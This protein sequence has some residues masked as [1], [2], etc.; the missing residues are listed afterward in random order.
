MARYEKINIQDLIFWG[1][2]CLILFW[3][4]GQRGLWASEGRWAEVAREMFLNKDFFHPKIN[5][6]PYFDKPL[7]T[8]WLVAAASLFTGGLNELAARLPSAFFAL[9]AIWA[10][11]RIGRQLWSK[12]VGDT[13]GWMLLA[14]YGLVFWGRTA[15]AE[16]ENLAAII[17]ATLW[18]IKRRD[19]LNFWTFLV[20]YLI[21]FIGAHTKGLTSVVVP[22]VIVFPDMI[23]DGRWKRLF[24]LGHVL[25]LI[26]AIAVYIC[27]FAY[28]D[29]TRGSYAESGLALMFRENV[30]RFI[31]PF[32]HKGPI[33]LYLYYLPLLLA[34]FS[35]LII[36]GAV[37]MLRFY[38]R[39]DRQTKW[40]IEATVLVFAF[41]T[42][43]GSRRGYY[44]LPILPFCALAGA[45]FIHE[46]NNERWK[47]IAYIIQTVV[48]GIAIVI[49]LCS[50][51]IWPLLEGRMGFI[52]PRGLRVATFALGVLAVLG[53]ALFKWKRVALARVGFLPE[54]FAALAICA[55][56][57]LG[58]FFCWQQQSLEK[59]RT[60]RKFANTLREQI[61]GI[62]SSRIGFYHS[63]SANIIFYLKTTEPVKVF[64]N[65]QQVLAF[66]CKGSGPRVLISRRKYL[67]DFMPLAKG[68]LSKGIQI[69]EEIYPW[70]RRKGRF[71]V[72]W[73]FM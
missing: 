18:Y 50:P 64:K 22:A 9:V 16:T 72:A 48:L 63:A 47:K 34:P 41:F 44:I 25:A 1:V 60:G 32:D 68:W 33:Y 39:L 69:G 57:L 40:L 27:P 52:A 59:Y 70:M 58:G 62:S 23:R 3:A 31:R 12:Q 28:A 42:A 14:T 56:V 71:Y 15:S 67:H 7:L 54:K 17:L 4:L 2:A 45:I 26:I 65:A 53:W 21:C 37:W 11:K 55:V 29:L 61:V 36:M 10:T 43:S 49:Y 35:P 24:G 66:V 73:K 51:A 8:Y 46:A 13:A 6:Q 30:I 5:G 38:K 19:G 20:F